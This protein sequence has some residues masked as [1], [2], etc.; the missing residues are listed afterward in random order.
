MYVRFDPVAA[1][2][3]IVLSPSQIVL[4]VGCVVM[5]GRSRTVM[6]LVYAFDV[7][8]GLEIVRVSV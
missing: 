1:A 5:V 2:L 3:N 8:H 7:P 4:F 6:F